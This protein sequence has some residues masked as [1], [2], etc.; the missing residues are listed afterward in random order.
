MK[1]LKQAA[2]RV[3]EVKADYVNEL[4]RR[5]YGK[6]WDQGNWRNY[7][8]KTS[9]FQEF[10]RLDCFS[11]RQI[12]AGFVTELGDDSV[13]LYIQAPKDLDWAAASVVD[14]LLRG[15]T[16]K[17]EGGGEGLKYAVAELVA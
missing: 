13:T 16:E 15:V 2:R 10:F 17:S 8:G 11:L 14:Y 6:E 9:P 5:L 7:G 3:T 1:N 12:E 4:G